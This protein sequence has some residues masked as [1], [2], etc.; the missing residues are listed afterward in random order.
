[1]PLGA[2]T[3]ARDLDEHGPSAALC[4]S[5]E[6]IGTSRTFGDE[7]HLIYGGAPGARARPGESG[8]QGPWINR[9]TRLEKSSGLTFFE[10]CQAINARQVPVEAIFRQ[11]CS[12]FFRGPVVQRVAVV[13]EFHS[14]NPV[15]TGVAHS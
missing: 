15:S 12:S 2:P 6:S 5:G 14:R 13:H 8:P 1:M 4:R 3:P 10:C 11:C 7:S 9:S